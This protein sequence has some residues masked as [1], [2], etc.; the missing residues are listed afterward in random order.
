MVLAYLSYQ[1]QRPTDET[2]HKHALKSV[3][4][5]LKAMPLSSE[6]QL[7]LDFLAYQIEG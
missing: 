2:T 3:L 7:W 1:Q 5:D 6:A 4:D